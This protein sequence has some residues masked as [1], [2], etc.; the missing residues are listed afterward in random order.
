MAILPV[1]DP[2]GS[3]I[4]GL[5]MEKESG[6]DGTM[7]KDHVMDESAWRARTDCHGSI[8]LAEQC[9]QSIPV[10]SFLACAAVGGMAVGPWI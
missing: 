4:A 6:E 8:Q 9:I 1:R 2:S 7:Q 5:V 10:L 3:W